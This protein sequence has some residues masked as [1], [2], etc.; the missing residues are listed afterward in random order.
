MEGIGENYE[1][2]LGWTPRPLPSG[3]FGICSRPLQW[4]NLRAL[5]CYTAGMLTEQRRKYAEARF[6][7]C[8][9]REAAIAAGCPPKTATQA[10]ARLE[11][12]PDVLM[13]IAALNG[14]QPLEM[15]SVI[16]N[17]NAAPIKAA[18]ATLPPLPEVE[19]DPLPTTQDPIEFLRAVMNC[20]RA[21]INERNKAAMKLAD[22]E[23]KKKPEEKP[24]ANKFQRPALKAVG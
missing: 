2:L 18:P 22:L 20:G 16:V 15:P 23:A 17:R 6:K 5:R 21:P 13:A 1:T 9:K 24:K 10:A 4:S 8:T 3:D 12:N 7:G 19:E 14:G 11:K